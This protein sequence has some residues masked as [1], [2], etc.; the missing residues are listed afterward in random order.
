MPRT[1]PNLIEFMAKHPDNTSNGGSLFNL[2][3]YVAQKE[4][5]LAD[6]FRLLRLLQPLET[7][8]LLSCLCSL[9]VTGWTPAESSQRFVMTSFRRPRRTQQPAEG[10]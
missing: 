2:V 8:P 10:L 7:S 6:E 4:A 5:V 9:L 1:K 3:D